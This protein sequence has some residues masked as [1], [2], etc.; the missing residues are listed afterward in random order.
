MD[1]DRQ[2]RFLIPPFFLYASLLSAA[3]IDPR[4]R[5]YIMPKLGSLKDFL[6]LITVAAVV[7]IP[8]GFTIGTITILLLRLGSSAAWRVCGHEPQIYEAWL[9]PRCFRQMVKK[10]RLH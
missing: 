1:Q 4:L 8:L 9:T 6:P 7:T 10:A 2:I 3:L 5:T